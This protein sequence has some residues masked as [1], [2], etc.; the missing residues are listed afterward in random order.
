MSRGVYMLTYQMLRK[1]EQ[2]LSST[3]IDMW[4][5]SCPVNGEKILKKF[6]SHVVVMDFNS[7]TLHANFHEKWVMT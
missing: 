3:D 6:K 7:N 1:E 5:T 4:I 2:G